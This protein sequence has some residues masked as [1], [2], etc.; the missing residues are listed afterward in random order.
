M[1]KGVICMTVIVQTRE[2]GADVLEQNWCSSDC[3]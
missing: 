2:E 3:V 1:H